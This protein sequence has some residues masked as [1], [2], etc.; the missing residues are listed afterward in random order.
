MTSEDQKM[1]KI[2]DHEERIKKLEEAVYAFQHMRSLG[3]AA[4]TKPKNVN[5]LLNIHKKKI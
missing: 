1:D 5:K 2:H 4:N 3:E